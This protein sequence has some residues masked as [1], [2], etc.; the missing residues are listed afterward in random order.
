MSIEDLLEEMEQYRSRRELRDYRP[1]WLKQFISGAANLLEPLTHVGRVGYE[2][3]IDDRGWTVCMYLGATEIV[4]GALDGQV[5]HASFQVDLQQ[6]QA[7]FQTVSRFEW[8]SL[9][10]PESQRPGHLVRSL[11]SI[12]GFVGEHHPVKLEILSVPPDVVRP[13][14]HRRPDGMIYEA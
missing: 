10:D 9:A 6:L 4:G 5:D 11:I 1:E 8:F 13:G 2:C 3:R 7:L 12:H 14:L